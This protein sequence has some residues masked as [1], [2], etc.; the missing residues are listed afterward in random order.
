MSLALS[1]ST[2]L[3]RLGV[4]VPL[5]VVRQLSSLVLPMDK[6][7]ISGYWIN[8]LTCER[9]LVLRSDG[10]TVWWKREKDIFCQ[11][12]EECFLTFFTPDNDQYGAA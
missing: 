9:V 10:D 11:A 4:R 12:T 7:K 3:V 6:P 5:L 1:E 8:K 2:S